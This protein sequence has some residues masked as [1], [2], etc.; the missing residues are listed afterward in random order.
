MAVMPEAE[1]K[2]QHGVWDPVPGLTTTSPYVNSRENTNTFTTGNPMPESTLS[3][4]QGLWI[5][6][7]TTCKV[8][9]FEYPFLQRAGGPLC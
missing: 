9:F 5:L 2:E 1:S 3:L 6:S 4:S 7:L 8:P